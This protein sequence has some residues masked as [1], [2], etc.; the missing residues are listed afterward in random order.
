M[1]CHAGPSQWRGSLLSSTGT[2][3]E[4]DTPFGFT[5]IG[6]IDWTETPPTRLQRTIA[7][8]FQVL[9]PQELH[10][11]IISHKI[12]PRAILH[13]IQAA[14]KKCLNIALKITSTLLILTFRLEMCRITMHRLTRS[15]KF[16][17]GY[18]HLSPRNDITTFDPV[19]STRWETG[20]YKPRNIG[21]GFAVFMRV[22]PMAQPCFA[23]E[24]PGLARPTLGKRKRYRRKKDC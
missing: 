5:S 22:N 20:S 11:T 4:A 8:A 12:A 24:V 1:A 3:M 10:Q 13:N 19:E 21:I 14:N 9:H 18:L 7:P 23:M 15:P 17:P 6:S 16:W 2:C